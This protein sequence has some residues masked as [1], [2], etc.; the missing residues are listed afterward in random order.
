MTFPLPHCTGIRQ[1]MSGL[2][3]CLSVYLY[4][5]AGGWGNFF[6]SVSEADAD[7]ADR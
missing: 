7:V 6:D 4:P 1:N 2:F 5:R 3:V